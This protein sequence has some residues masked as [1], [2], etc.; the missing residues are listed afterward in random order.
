MRTATLVV[1]AHSFAVEVADTFPLRAQGLS[2]RE[3][4]E[5][6]HGMLFLFNTAGNHPFWM[7]DMK[8]A[9]DFV[10]INGNKV[11]G[12]KEN[13]SPK[14]SMLSLPIYYPPEEVD[15]V[16]ELAAGTVARLGVKVGDGVGVRK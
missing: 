4:L 2:G 3:N 6:N 14:G 10:W 8:F 13:V 16:L 1:G 15:M 12:T 9:L 7:K 5:E 11:V